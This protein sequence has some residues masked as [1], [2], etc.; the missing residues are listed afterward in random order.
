M[1]G[2][3]TALSAWGVAVANSGRRHA[4]RA[5]YQVENNHDTNLREEGDDR[6]L[7]NVG[8]LNGIQSDIRGIQSDIRGIRRDVGRHSDQLLDT[9]TRDA[10]REIVKEVNNEQQN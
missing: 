6:H 5:R 4:K 2:I 8:L 10:V 9:L 3:T 1:A 7:E